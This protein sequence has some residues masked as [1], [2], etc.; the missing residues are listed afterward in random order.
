MAESRVSLRASV[1]RLLAPS[2]TAVSVTDLARILNIDPI[3][4]SLREVI[5]GFETARKPQR[6]K[7]V[8]RESAPKTGLKIVAYGVLGANGEVLNFPKDFIVFRIRQGDR[9]YIVNNRG[10]G[11]LSSLVIA[12]DSVGDDDVI[13]AAADGLHKFSLPNCP[14]FIPA[15][16]EDEPSEGDLSEDQ[17]QFDMPGPPESDR[18]DPPDTDEKTSKHDG[19]D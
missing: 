6:V 8:I 17:S 10:A 19:G 3:P 16:F 5:H 4:H 15:E 2:G 13:E 14:K 9:F 11:R 1:E 12:K 18:A 7:C